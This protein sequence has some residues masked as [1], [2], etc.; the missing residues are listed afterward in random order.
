VPSSSSR[1][2]RPGENLYLL[3]LVRDRFEYPSLRDTAI[4]LAYRFEPD[5][6]L[7]EH[8]ST[9]DRFGTESF[10]KNAISSSSSIPKRSSATRS[11]AFTFSRVNLPL[12]AC[13]FREMHHSCLHWR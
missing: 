7:I 1:R 10:G 13:Y 11:A 8:S 6:I 5:E 12:V 2:A 3:D 9:R 4:E